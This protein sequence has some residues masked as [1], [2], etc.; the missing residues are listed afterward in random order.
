MTEIVY[1]AVFEHVKH[2]TQ[3]QKE[4][5]DT[6]HK[7][8]DLVPGTIVMI[9]VTEKQ[10]K[11]DPKYKGFYTVVRKTAANTY[12]LKNEKG[13]LKPKN[14]PPSLLKKVSNKILEQKNDFFEVE[15]IIGHKKDDMNNYLY[16]CKWLDYDESHD[17]W[18]PEDYFTVPKFIKE[19]WQRIG[20]APE[21]IKDINKAN[22]RL[23][24]DMK[25]VNSISKEKSDIKR[26]SYTMTALQK[27]KHSKI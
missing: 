10:N 9:L 19:Y 26:K 23:L 8:I 15:A 22:K 20:E 12:V 7:M 6:S 24:K 4:H 18:E 13:F 25:V 21:S 3:K 1:P 14:Y 11:L 17:T 16:R 2:I 5:F 27:K